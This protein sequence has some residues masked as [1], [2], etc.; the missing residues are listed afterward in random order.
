MISKD[1]QNRAEKL[2]KLIAYHGHAYHTLDAP[3]ISDEAY[4]SLVKELEGLEAT[5]PKLKTVDTVSDRVGGEP[6]KEFVKV[7]HE[8]RQWSFNDAFN[9]DEMKDWEDRILNF[10]KKAGVQDEKIEYCCELKIDGLKIVLTYEDGK[11]ARGVTR[12][13]GV[14]G[15]DVTN[16]VRTITDIPLELSDKV[17]LIAGGEAWIGKSDLVKINAARGKTGLPLYANTR[18][19]AA[20]SIRQLDPKIAAARNLHFFTY[21]LEQV[22]NTPPLTQADELGFLKSLGFSVSPQFKICKT[23]NEVQKY[24]EEWTRKKDTLEYGLD[25]IVVKIN[26]RRIQEALGFTGKAPRWA[27]A[28][29]FP[30]EQ[31]TTVVEDI[32]LQIGRQGT[33]TPVAHLRPVVVAGSTV[34]RATL[35]N[36]DEI[37]RLDV[38]IG[39]TVIL[40]KAGDVIPDIVS[41]VKELRT[42]KER[43]YVWPKRVADCGGGGEIERVPGEAA[44]RCKN[45][46]SFSQ[47]KRR[48]YHFVGKHAFDIDGLGPKVI[49]A[50]F[51]AQLISEYADIFTLKKGDL[52]ALERF[53]EKSADNLLEAIEK[54]RAATLARLIIGLSIPQ[55]GEETAILLAQNCGSI[56]RLKDEKMERL[57]EISGVGPIVAEEIVKWFADKENTK[58]LDKLL[59]QIKIKQKVASSEEQGGKFKGKTFVLTGTLATM[60]RDEAKDKIR[61]LG[62]SV[63]SSVS[64]ETDYVVAGES[65][66]S[67]YEKALELGVKILNESEFQK[68]L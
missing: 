29:K 6:L 23:L 51:D 61:A 63:S 67:K 60:T 3:E 33:L 21:D 52:L 39:D 55:V 15:E 11:L 2:R 40:Q 28:Y 62:G 32:V 65:A 44:W 19:L 57:E 36:E 37:K 34:S 56:E 42:G 5:F 16:N 22:N 66:G 30:A 24:Y 1:I 50:L 53:A 4:D 49:D 38:R 43:E 25:G 8:V 48:F 41:V 47:I 12:G 17:S 27:I 20:G 59:K 9:F 54:S 7:E 46:N 26:S 10:A 58:Q 68:M 18:N 45:K 64:K 31:V 35:H 14:V 13:D